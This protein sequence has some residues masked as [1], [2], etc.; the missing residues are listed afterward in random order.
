MVGTQSL[1]SGAHSL[2]PL[3]LPTLQRYTIQFS[4]SYAFSRRKAPEL[5][6]RYPR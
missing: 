5:L 3:A 2:D 1:S 4:N 6:H